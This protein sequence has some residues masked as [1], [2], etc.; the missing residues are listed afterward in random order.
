MGGS[1]SLR[2][3]SKVFDGFRLHDVSL[4]LD[5]G[6][7]FVLVGPTGSGKTLLLE[8]IN[9]FHAVDSG[10]ILFNGEDITALPPNK[11]SI[12]YVPQ[13]PNLSQERTLRENLEYIVKLRKLPGD[14]SHEV[15]GVM[16]MVGLAEY[17]DRPTVNLS[18]GEKRKAALARAVI[19]RPQLLLL[20]EPLSSLDVTSK[21][22]LLDEIAMIQRYL[23][24]TVIH[25][26]HD[27]QEALG[28]ADKLGVM[29]R[30]TIVK[31]GTVEQVYEDPVDEYAARFLGFQ[32][33]YD[34]ELSEAGRRITKMRL[35]D[36]VLR[37]ARAP[38]QGQ[39]RV[40]IHSDDV[41][42]TRR[43]PVSTRDNVFRGT[44]QTAT[45]VGPSVTVAVDIGV[46]MVIDLSRRGFLEQGIGPGD[47]VW[48]R[49]PPEAVKMLSA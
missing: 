25:V 16:E 13:T 32:N 28:L 46:K 6:D 23:G 1:L 3:V 47:Q 10:S 41:S 18:G 20:D 21:A 24:C 27:Q 36:L 38:A 15:Q 8:T 5:P 48:V 26:T 49:F 19:L 14:W 9:G 43:T 11:R 40:G 34:A 17:A 4:E 37:A 44:V 33:V 7:Y 35:G 45:S 22:G 2:G 12:G 30:G 31:V 42:V 29:R 39:T